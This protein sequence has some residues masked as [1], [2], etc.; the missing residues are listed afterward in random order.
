MIVFFL[1]F[2]NLVKLFAIDFQILSE[3]SQTL[4]ECLGIWET[5]K[6]NFSTRSDK[7]S[8]RYGTSDPRSQA[9]IAYLSS[10]GRDRLAN[11]TNRRVSMKLRDPA[12]FRSSISAQKKVS[13]EKPQNQIRDIQSCAVSSIVNYIGQNLD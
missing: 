12:R 5:Y 7:T 13:P 10:W 11:G 8:L 2:S 6:I 9:G 3:N 4:Q 1:Y